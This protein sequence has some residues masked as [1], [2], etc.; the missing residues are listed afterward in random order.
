MNV[1]EKSLVVWCLSAILLMAA[2]NREHRSCYSVYGMSSPDELVVLSTEGDT[3]F[4]DVSGIDG[5][6]FAALIPGDIAEIVYHGAYRHGMP[7]S[8][9]EISS[10]PLQPVGSDRDEHGC[11]GS[12]GYVWSEARQTCIRPFEE[13]IE[14]P[15]ISGEGRAFLVLGRDSL[16][17][18]LFTPTEGTILLTRHSLPGNGEVW[19]NSDRWTLRRTGDLWE[20][21]LNGEPRY[22][23]NK[24]R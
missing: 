8:E 21:G 12:A 23:I 3:L 9:V 5:G 4:F 22:C 2:C 20:A 24:N 1:R 19:E 15:A 6:V 10:G 18:E 13:G 14:L 16:F 17:A 7:V 11:I